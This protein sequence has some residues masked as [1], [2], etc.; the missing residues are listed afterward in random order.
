[1]FST[2][3][4]LGPKASTPCVGG[5]GRRHERSNCQTA[6]MNLV[7]ALDHYESQADDDAATEDQEA[8]ESIPHTAMEV[9]IELVP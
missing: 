8:F 7:F 2:A 9:P 3:Y 5:V 4:G 1:M 6:G